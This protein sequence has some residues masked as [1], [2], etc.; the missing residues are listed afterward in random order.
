[1]LTGNL[2]QR[3]WLLGAI[4][5]SRTVPKFLRGRVKLYPVLAPDARWHHF[6]KPRFCRAY[7]GYQLARL[8]VEQVWRTLHEIADG[9]EPILLCWEKAP[10]TDD[11]WCH[12]RLVAAWFRARLGEVVDELEP[13]P[14]QR[15]LF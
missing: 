7:F 6:E 1:M 15:D 8:D 13:P 14:R 10:F 2:I 5:I 11:N 12:R 3:G 9:A 4:A